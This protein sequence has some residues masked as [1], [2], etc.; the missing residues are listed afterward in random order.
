MA[1]STTNPSSL[2]PIK[3]QPNTTRQSNPPLSSTSF[4]QLREQRVHYLLSLILALSFTKSPICLLQNFNTEKRKRDGSD[5][6]INSSSTDR[7]AGFSKFLEIFACRQPRWTEPSLSVF[8][9]IFL[10]CFLFE[11]FVFLNL[12]EREICYEDN[13]LPLL[14]MVEENC[15]QNR[16]NIQSPPLSEISLSQFSDA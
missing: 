14:S 15:W 9:S 13:K 10:F 12:W 16:T 11:W 1:H 5:D 8:F 2:S 4:H 6:S 7:N 3:S